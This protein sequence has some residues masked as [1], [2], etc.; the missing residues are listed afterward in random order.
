[1]EH[2]VSAGFIKKVVD[3]NLVA[4]EVSKRVACNGDIPVEE[5]THN[6][7]ISYPT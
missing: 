6:L 2:E 5:V 4:S 1:M 7:P 3:P